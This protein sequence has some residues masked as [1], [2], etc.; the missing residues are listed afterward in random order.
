MEIILIENVDNLG[1]RGDVVNVAGGYARNYLIPKGLAILATPGNLK[2]VEQQKLKWAKKEAKEKEEAETVAKS[3]ENLEIEIFKKVGEEESLYGSV[4]S[5]DI[6][7]K[8]NELG[9][10]IDKKKVSLD[11]PLKTLGEYTVPIKLHREVIANVKVIVKP[12]E[13]NE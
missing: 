2:F 9:Y 10:N 13:T 3:I 12:E 11:H 7:D 5:H 4:T 8:L 6:A 1:R